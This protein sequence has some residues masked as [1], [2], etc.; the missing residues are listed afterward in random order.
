MLSRLINRKAG[1]S[2]GM[3]GLEKAIGNTAGFALLAALNYHLAH[4]Q[5]QQTA[6]SAHSSRNAVIGST[7][8]ARAAGRS[9]ETISTAER[10]S[11]APNQE[12]ESLIVTP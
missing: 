5:S 8:A 7:W 1:V 11:N 10:T 6:P 9:T 2:A 4:A 3:V 12:T